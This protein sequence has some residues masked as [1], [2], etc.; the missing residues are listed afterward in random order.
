[1]QSDKFCRT[2]RKNKRKGIQHT[3][4]PLVTWV[5]I[6]T[7]FLP[8]YM[9]SSKL[10][11]LSGLSCLICKMGWVVSAVRIK[12]HCP[13]HVVGTLKSKAV[14]VNFFS[15]VLRI[16]RASRVQEAGE[17]VNPGSSWLLEPRPGQII[18]S[19]SSLS[20][21]YNGKDNQVDFVAPQNFHFLIMFIVF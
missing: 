10:L 20:L 17:M 19:R 12:A 3:G 18:S 15:D 9:T 11:I 16:L 4:C 2:F 13:K 5:Q 21:L 7:V 1:M 6:L 8:C 14:V